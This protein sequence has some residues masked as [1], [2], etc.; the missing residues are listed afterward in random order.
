MLYGGVVLRGVFGRNRGCGR[1]VIVR[2]P[3]EVVA[4]ATS[5]LATYSYVQAKEVDNEV[6]GATKLQRQEAS[7]SLASCFDLVS[8][9]HVFRQANLAAHTMAHLAPL[10]FSTRVWDGGCPS[11][12]DD[13]IAADY[14]LINNRN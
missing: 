8:F 4:A 14:C 7:W 9:S 10:E 11:E 13:V 1:W 6:R 3:A 5:L 2:H 12:V